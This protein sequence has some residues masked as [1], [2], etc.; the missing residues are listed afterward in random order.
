MMVIV[1]NFANFCDDDSGDN[2]DDDNDDGNN[3]G[4]KVLHDP[5]V[6]RMRAWRRARLI[7]CGKFAASG[8]SKI[9]TLV[10]HSDSPGLLFSHTRTLEQS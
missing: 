9:L 1:T 2:G 5:H 3:A 10:G 8:G 6:M 7:L 4:N